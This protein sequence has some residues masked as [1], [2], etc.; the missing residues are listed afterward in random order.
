[1]AI[2]T[3]IGGAA[4]AAGSASVGMF[5][6]ARTVMPDTWLLLVP[7]AISALAACTGA[8]VAVVSYLRH[9][10]D[11]NEAKQA[12]ADHQEHDNVRFDEIERLVRSGHRRH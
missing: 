11:V 7:T 9:R 2:H 6:T 1:L 12:L 5:A 4:M 3:I 10:K 8:A